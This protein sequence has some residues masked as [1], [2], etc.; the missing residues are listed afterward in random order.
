M[1][2]NIRTPYHDPNSLF[3]PLHSPLCTK[4]PLPSLVVS[5]APFGIV[6]HSPD[7]KILVVGKNQVISY[8]FLDFLVIFGVS[9]VSYMGSGILWHSYLIPGTLWH[10]Y[11]PLYDSWHP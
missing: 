10:L 9:T 5:L 6:G 3:R 8:D 2:E 1:V 11:R 4:I 7:R